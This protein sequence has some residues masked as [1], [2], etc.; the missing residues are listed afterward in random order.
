M[1]SVL[2]ILFYMRNIYTIIMVNNIYLKFPC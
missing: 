1:F 2:K